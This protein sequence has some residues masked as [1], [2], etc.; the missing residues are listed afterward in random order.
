MQ[1]ITILTRKKLTTVTLRLLYFV[2]MIY[3][4]VFSYYNRTFGIPVTSKIVII[5]GPKSI[6]SIN[7]IN[8]CSTFPVI[9]IS[10]KL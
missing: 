3:L 10:L 4:Y 5:P 6:E 1:N 2:G 7:L 8:Y 9:L